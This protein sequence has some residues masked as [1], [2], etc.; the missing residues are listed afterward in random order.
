MKIRIPISCSSALD[1][2]IRGHSLAIMYHFGLV[3]TQPGHAEPVRH[4][5]EAVWVAF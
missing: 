5:A 1:T 2:S 3:R 4:K